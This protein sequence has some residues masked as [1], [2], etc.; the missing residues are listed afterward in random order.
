MRHDQRGAGGRSTMRGRSD[1]RVAGVNEA[2]RPSMSVVADKATPVAGPGAPLVGVRVDGVRRSVGVTTESSVQAQV[3][4]VL[5][6]RHRLP[7]LW[8]RAA[9]VPAA[10]GAAGRSESPQPSAC[11]GGRRACRPGASPPVLPSPCPGRRAGPEWSTRRHMSTRRAD[12]RDRAIPP[13]C[14]APRD[15]RRPRRSPAR[16]T[17]AIARRAR[18]P[19][20]CSRRRRRGAAWSSPVRSAE[21]GLIE[22]SRS[23]C[24]AV[25]SR[26]RAARPGRGCT[27]R[28]RDHGS[29]A[30]S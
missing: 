9:D 29:G 7:R 27:S 10:P 30:G 20:A 19:T 25:V 14:V 22:W 24:R 11:P 17:P 5:G 28:G 1:G 18:E 26:G 2:D 13:R 23:R 12:R 3:G 21:P 8:E 15:R 4:R 16:R 6:S